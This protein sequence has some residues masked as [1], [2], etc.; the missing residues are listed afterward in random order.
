MTKFKLLLAGFFYSTVVV[1]AKAA[2]CATGERD[3]NMPGGV[4]SGNPPAH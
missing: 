3:S 1:A 2:T 4:W